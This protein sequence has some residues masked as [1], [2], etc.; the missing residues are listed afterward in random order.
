ME[1]NISLREYLTL[2]IDSIEKLIEERFAQSQ[3]AL[4]LES[5][6]VSRRLEN[7]NGEASR[8]REMQATYVPRELFELQINKTENAL[9]L[10]S[11]AS[12][13]QILNLNEKVDSLKQ[14]RDV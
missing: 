10:A 1:N 3:K 11:K 8:L 7:L 2:R 14:S 9:V 12:D 4:D 5:K 6:E 13:T